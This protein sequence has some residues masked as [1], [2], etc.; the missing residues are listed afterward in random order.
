MA[1]TIFDAHQYALDCG[2]DFSCI[3]ATAQ[4]G[5]SDTDVVAIN[6]WAGVH[7][8]DYDPPTAEAAAAEAEAVSAAQSA[9]LAM[10]AWCEARVAATAH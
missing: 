9:R 10:K 4:H 7:S 1:T 8:D 2:W 5:L 3:E 6:L